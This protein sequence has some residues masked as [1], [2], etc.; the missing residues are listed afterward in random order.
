MIPCLMIQKTQAL[1][2][3]EDLTKIRQQSTGDR[4]SF[5]PENEARNLVNR[6]ASYI[7]YWISYCVLFVPF[8]QEQR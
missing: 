6:Q 7:S 5:H 2:D 3:E 8:L 1:E 4:P